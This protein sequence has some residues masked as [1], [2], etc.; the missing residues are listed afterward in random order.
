MG[1]KGGGT[2]T[3]IQ[4]NDPPAYVAPY[5][6][7]YLQRAGAQS[8]S[9]FRAYTGDF[10]GFNANGSMSQGPAPT[11]EQFTRTTPGTPGTTGLNQGYAGSIPGTPGTPASTSF[12]QQGYKA[13]LD[14]YNQSAQSSTPFNPQSYLD[15]RIAPMNAQ[16]NL[17]LDLTQQRALAGSPV[18]N[19]AKTNLQD[20]LEGKY[21]TADSNPYL[22]GAVDQQLG[23]IQSRINTQFG[24]SNFGTTAHQ[25]WLGKNLADTALPIYAQNYDTERNRQM[26]ANLFA[27]QA[28]QADYG[29]LQ[30]LLGVGDTRQANSQQRLDA[31]YDLWNQQQQYPQMQLDNLGRAISGSPGMQSTSTGP[32]PYQ[33][34]RAASAIGGAAA[35][36]GLGG[37]VAGASSGAIGG[38]M[39]MGVGAALGLLGGML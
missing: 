4:K 27:P 22:K 7:D 23:D 26:Q 31:L 3:T 12:D 10:S 38:P 21:L 18:L 36:A 32:N 9:P 24:G 30:A 6:T 1:Q 11:Q 13:A 2:Q 35:G 20:T 17:G 19:A 37:M 29:D 39:G 5:A 14:K 15:A 34:N 16:Q 25:E 8:N 28:A 33:Q